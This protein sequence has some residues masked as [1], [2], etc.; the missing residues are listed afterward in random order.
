[1]RLG[2]RGVVFSL[3][4]SGRAGPSYDGPGPLE[5]LPYRVGV[6]VEDGRRPAPETAPEVASWE[7]ESTRQ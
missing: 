7:I 1:V 6:A 2:L 5:I 3:Y 4:Y